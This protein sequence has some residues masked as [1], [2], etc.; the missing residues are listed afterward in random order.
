MRRNVLA[1]FLCAESIKGNGVV[2]IPDDDEWDQLRHVLLID[3]GCVGLGHTPSLG[4]EA[5]AYVEVI[6]PFFWLEPRANKWLKT[7]WEEFAV[8]ILVTL[9]CVS[10]EAKEGR[11]PLYVRLTAMP[12]GLPC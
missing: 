10:E 5:D 1:K 7:S 6:L 8:A 4:S 3:K 12:D 9:L 11:L 2:P